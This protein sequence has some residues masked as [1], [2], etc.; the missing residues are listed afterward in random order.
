M[1][2]FPNVGPTAGKTEGFEPH[3]L[4]RDVAGEDHEVGPGNRAAVLL[5]DRPE[6]APRLLEVRV[7]RPAI[8]R[9]KAL[10]PP[11][12]TASTVTRAIRAR[13][14]PG[15]PNEQGPVVTEV[16]RPPVLRVRHERR[17]ILFQGG[18]VEALEL[19]GIVEVRAHR[20]GSGRMLV[21]QVQG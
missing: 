10:L 11:T 8:Q 18:E 20:V 21:Q 16:G 12:A 19:P 4:E 5:L 14:V 9:R 17:E 3:R 13:A 15:H 7:I 1:I 6:Q 2:R